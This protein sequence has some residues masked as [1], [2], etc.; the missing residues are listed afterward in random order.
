VFHLLD[1][2]SI[3]CMRVFCE[4]DLIPLDAK[5]QRWEDSPLRYFWRI[6]SL[7]HEYGK[8]FSNELKEKETWET[9]KESGSDRVIGRQYEEDDVD[10]FQIGFKGNF[11]FDCLSSGIAEDLAPLDSSFFPAGQ[12]LDGVEELKRSKF[13]QVHRDFQARYLGNVKH[14]AVLPHSRKARSTYQKAAKQIDTW[15]SHNKNP[16]LKVYKGSFKDGSWLMNEAILVNKVAIKEMPDLFKGYHECFIHTF[17]GESIAKLEDLK[18]AWSSAV[19]KSKNIA[20]TFE[21]SSGLDKDADLKNWLVKVTSKSGFPKDKNLGINYNFNNLELI[22]VYHGQWADNNTD[23]RKYCDCGDR[24]VEINDISVSTH[25]DWKR[26]LDDLYEGQEVVFTIAKKDENHANTNG[27][28]LKK[29]RRNRAVPIYLQST[30]Q[31]GMYNA[32]DNWL[33]RSLRHLAR[34][35]LKQARVDLSGHCIGG[36]FASLAAAHIRSRFPMVDM[37]VVTWG[38]PMVGNENFKLLYKLLDLDKVTVRLVCGADP[39]PFMPSARPF[40]RQLVPSLSGAFSA[41]P[42]SS[43]KFKNEYEHVCVKT[44]LQDRDQGLING[45]EA[46]SISLCHEIPYYFAMAQ[47]QYDPT[48]SN[49][50]DPLWKIVKRNLLKAAKKYITRLPKALDMIA[51]GGFFK[52][53]I[54][55]DIDD[56]AGDDHDSSNP[57]EAG[58]RAEA[59]RLAEEIRLFMGSTQTQ[60][61]Q[62]R[63]DMEDLLFETREKSEHMEEMLRTT[64]FEQEALNSQILDKMNSQAKQAEQLLQTGKRSVEENK[65]SDP[66]RCEDL[67]D[68]MR[69]LQ[70][71]TET[72][73]NILAKHR[74]KINSA[75]KNGNEQTK[76]MICE[77]ESKMETGIQD[78]HKGLN[79]LSTHIDAGFQEQQDA[80]EKSL[81]NAVSIRSEKLIHDTVKKTL[82]QILGDPEMKQARDNI[83]SQT[84]DDLQ[85]QFGNAAAFESM[86]ELV[87]VAEDRLEELQS[88][89]TECKWDHDIKAYNEAIRVAVD[90]CNFL[91]QIS[92]FQ[93]LRGKIAELKKAVRDDD[94]QQAMQLRQDVEALQSRLNIDKEVGDALGDHVKLKGKV[95]D[96]LLWQ[97][98]YEERVQK[99][100]GLFRIAAEVYKACA[101]E[102]NS[103]LVFDTNMQSPDTAVPLH[104]KDSFGNRP[105]TH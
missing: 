96:Y 31:D 54:S 8:Q 33:G 50:N 98:Y 40:L 84:P 9:L 86:Q 3:H 29:A 4:H 20:I 34:S 57:E 56:E 75:I 15:T 82:A 99:G 90:H 38:A 97:K 88:T 69:R 95:N 53:L 14:E 103:F 30:I 51:T 66:F 71:A 24:I 72:I 11:E 105:G 102:V 91:Q 7:V 44:S 89:K 100:E 10:V 58:H 32:V 35:P 17:N 104:R 76:K 83:E 12:Q 28:N 92:S 78:L 73:S 101:C 64:I 67:I 36:A 2:N 85:A 37:R 39:M 74:K 79:T 23:L 41:M 43:E 63:S 42:T 65:D 47:C 45:A 19:K 59:R 80:L 61:A 18:F 13:P 26:A 77:M 49:W 70:G 25:K 21:K 81:T 48:C 1:M 87:R 46:F 60:M 68:E 22:E 5:T 62:V 16:F 55:P 52:E 27:R 94:R 93:R 6:A